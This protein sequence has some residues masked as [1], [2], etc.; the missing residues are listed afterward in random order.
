M[1]IE[2]LLGAL[3]VARFIEEHYLRLPFAR[4]GGCTYLLSL[5]DWERLATLLSKPEADVLVGRLGE[6]GPGQRPSTSDESRAVLEAGY[7]IGIRRAHLLDPELQALA[8]GLEHELGGAV[9]VQMYATPAGQPGFGWH[10]DAEEVFILQTQGSKEWLL[11]KNTVNPWPLIE[12]L[13]ADMRYHREMMPVLACTLHPGDWLYIPAGYWHRTQAGEPSLSLSVGI[14]APSAVDV[15]DALRPHLL[16][17]LRWRQRLPVPGSVS[18][19]EPQERERRYRE[20]FAEL[21]EDL[22]R[23]LR[24]ESFVHSFLA[25]YNPPSEQVSQKPQSPSLPSREEGT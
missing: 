19:L 3:P 22:S 13:P 1:V 4:A 5:G 24:E 15:F 23:L 14:R 6:R 18:P 17:S 2:Q 8:A 12:T 25:R 16:D 11:R 20:L 10:Y 9:D 21:A 7:T